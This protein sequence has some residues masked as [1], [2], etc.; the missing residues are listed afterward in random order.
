M[1]QVL[2]QLPNKCKTLSSIP[3]T[4]NKKGKG[5]KKKEEEKKEE[6]EEKKMKEKEEEERRRR[7]VFQVGSGWIEDLQTETTSNM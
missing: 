5:E 7:R 2:E 4:V 6:E 1:D 3:S